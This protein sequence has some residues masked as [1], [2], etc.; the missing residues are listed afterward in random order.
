MKKILICDDETDIRDVL[1]MLIEIEF[2][3]EITHASDGQEGIE[4]LSDDKSFDL[5]IC[6]MNM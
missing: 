2:D 1:E 6:D 3:V 5:I 4:L